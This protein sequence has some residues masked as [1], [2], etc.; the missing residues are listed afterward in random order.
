MDGVVWRKKY[1]M[2]HEVHFADVDDLKK[3]FPFSLEEPSEHYVKYKIIEYLWKEGKLNTEIKD[4]NK[5][6]QIYHRVFKELYEEE[7]L[8]F[9]LLFQ[10]FVVVTIQSYIKYT[11]EFNYYLD[12]LT[13]EEL[14]S[15]F[16]QNRDFQKYTCKV[17]VEKVYDNN[18][19]CEKVA[20]ELSLSDKCSFLSYLAVRR[21]K[22]KSNSVHDILNELL[23]LKSPG[24]TAILIYNIRNKLEYQRKK[25][26]W[27]PNRNLWNME[28]M[29][30]T[31]ILDFFESTSINMYQEFIDCDLELRIEKTQFFFRFL[32]MIAAKF[33]SSNSLILL[34]SEL[35]NPTILEWYSEYTSQV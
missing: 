17:L 18:T 12:S 4:F 34:G 1:W 6:L 32:S 14:L 24:G 13:I 10:C 22:I 19:Q 26:T 20:K 35:K 28:L 23:K 25:I 11:R 2:I 29:Y 21:V 9:E 27:F 16:Q 5:F 7:K 3:Q 33:F 15:L 31:E 30:M 8:S